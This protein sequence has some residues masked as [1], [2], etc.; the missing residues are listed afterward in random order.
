MLTS[1]L[2]A[3]LPED[4]AHLGMDAVFNPATRD[5]AAPAYARAHEAVVAFQALAAAVLCGITAWCFRGNP[6]SAVNS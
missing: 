3:F 4:I 6:K 5:A 1:L 2:L